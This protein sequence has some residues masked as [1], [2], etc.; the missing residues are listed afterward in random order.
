[1]PTLKR[2]IRRTN[3]MMDHHVKVEMTLPLAKATAARLVEIAP[4]MGYRL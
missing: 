3:R 4:R 2:P 1:M